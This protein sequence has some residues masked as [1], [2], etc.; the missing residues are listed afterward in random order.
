MYIQS[1]FVQSDGARSVMEL[2]LNTFIKIA[3]NQN[4]EKS[5]IDIKEMIELYLSF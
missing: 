3:K 4:Y 1:Q 2:C 5:K